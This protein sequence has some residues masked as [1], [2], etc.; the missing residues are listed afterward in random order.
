[1][2]HEP[3]ESGDGAPRAAAV[4]YTPGD[5]I[6]G[7][8][9]AVVTRR[10]GAGAQGEVYALWNMALKARF[11]VK[12]LNAELVGHEAERMF[13]KEAQLM[14][15]LRHPNIVRVVDA[16]WTKEAVRR[17]YYITDEE[18][19]A[20][21]LAEL[22]ATRTP[23]AVL[24]VLTLGMQVCDALHRAHTLLGPNK[25][26]LGAIHRDVKPANL[27][28]AEDDD[29]KVTVK[30]LDFGIA[31]ALH[32]V[33]SGVVESRF[34]GTVAYA[35]PEQQIG[36]AL[37]QTDLYSLCVVLYELL[38]DRHPFWDAADIVDL[39]A[40][41]RF[42]KARPLTEYVI[43][44]PDRLV[45]LIA[46]NLEKDPTKRSASA[47]ELKAELAACV[48]EVETIKKSRALDQATTDNMLIVK[49]VE[50]RKEE[51]DK[52][53]ATAL[54]VHAERTGSSADLPDREWFQTGPVGPPVEAPVRPS[55]ASLAAHEAP[56][57]P[58]PP[59]AV[60][61]AVSVAAVVSIP[62]T[63]PTGAGVSFDATSGRPA[64]ILRGAPAV[65]VGTPLVVPRKAGTFATT[66]PDPPKPMQAP[67]SVARA[68]GP[69]PSQNARMRAAVTREQEIPPPTERVNPDGSTKRSTGTTP[70]SEAHRAAAQGPRASTAF[71]VDAPG[72]PWYSNLSR[73]WSRLWWTVWNPRDAWSRWKLRRSLPI[74]ERDPRRAAVTTSRLG[75]VLIVI[76]AIG[77][78]LSFG[79]AMNQRRIAKQ[80]ASA[81]SPAA[82]TALPASAPAIVS[83]VVPQPSVQSATP[84]A[85]SAM[86]AP[87]ASASA[88]MASPVACATPSASA[89]VHAKLSSGPVPM[90][91]S[92]PKSFDPT[93]PHYP[94]APLKTVPKPAGESPKVG[95]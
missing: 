88:L 67:P 68:N 13:Q 38:A 3:P 27:L 64:Q 6:A 92:S 95:M 85:T 90:R 56:F 77:G 55:Y 62:P 44:L 52:S 49:R 82:T 21:P 75:R 40:L 48:R 10:L 7:L 79:W 19:G 59:P 71:M 8:D 87:S 25:E 51:N 23:M 72:L 31:W 34:M 63:L 74:D 12:L 22:I 30:V 65:P 89:P 69:T 80:S 1:M 39:L 46:K 4:V 94:T 78:V 2:R 54:A 57:R 18:V 81:D 14:I 17:P 41:H 58:A 9:N 36:R 16:G 50:A 45:A 42:S 53:V 33:I 43:G 84:P 60:A 24:N 76:A 29:G 37:V 73:G 86:S 15:R 26:L 11:V 47:A 28:L 5:V 83:S 91:A 70:L 61:P 35:A 93:Q 20:V 32:H 66:E